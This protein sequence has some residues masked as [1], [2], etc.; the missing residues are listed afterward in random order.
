MKISMIRRLFI[1]GL[2]VLPCS[3]P[4][5]AATSKLDLS[6]GWIRLLPAKLPAGGYFTLHNHSDQS[7]KLIAA[8]SPAYGDVMLH[9]SAESNGQ[10]HMMKVESV[11][12]PA[13]GT[14]KFAPG[15]YHLMLMQPKTSLKVGDEVNIT[16]RFN[17]GEK[18]TAPF[19]LRPAGASGP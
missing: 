7:V 11:V 2:L 8:T 12:V 10:S 1:L 13:H 16:L 15:G 14:L 18:L 5:H 9:H 6:G 19:K 3:L 17:D 4:L